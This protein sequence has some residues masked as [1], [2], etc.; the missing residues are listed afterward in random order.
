MNVSKDLDE[1]CY[2]DFKI[3]LLHAC[4]FCKVPDS[5]ISFMV[6]DPIIPFMVSDPTIS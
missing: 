3:L 5:I 1:T 2:I 6:T 4:S